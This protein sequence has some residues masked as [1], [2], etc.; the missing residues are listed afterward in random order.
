MLL[1][2]AVIA[3]LPPLL[4]QTAWSPWLYNSLVVLVIACPC[5]LVISTPVSIVAGLTSAARNG[6][7]IK[8]GAYLE[9]PARLRAM[10]FDKTGTL[11]YGQTEVRQVIPLDDHTQQELLA[12]AAAM[13]IHSTHPL[14]RAILN[15][16]RQLGLVAPGRGKL[17]RLPGRRA[18]TR[19]STTANTGSAVTACWNTGK[20]KPSSSMPWPPGWKMPAIRWCSCGAKTMCAA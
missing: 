12:H 2:A 11:T 16:A 5:A 14:G 18:R 8:G 15:Q 19:P 3:L 6:V 1:L 13:E 7:L 9:A 4:L 17:H 20:P 10:A